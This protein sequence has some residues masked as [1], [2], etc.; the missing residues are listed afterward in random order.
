ML[1]VSRGI[2]YWSWLVSLLGEGALGFH[3]D[4]TILRK[5]CFGLQNMEITNYYSMF[6]VMKYVSDGLWGEGLCLLQGTCVF[7]VHATTHMVTESLG[8]SILGVAS[9]R[10]YKESNMLHN[11]LLTREISVSSFHYYDIGGLKNAH[12]S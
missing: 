8:I 6:G 10:H 5:N 4:S 7:V 11:Y 1:I 3:I 2:A 12:V 9:G